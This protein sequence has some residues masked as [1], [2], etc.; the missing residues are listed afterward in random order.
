MFPLFTI[1]SFIF[2]TLIGSFL[3]VVILRYNTGKNIFGPR[4]RSVCF[5]CSK[6]LAWH[7]LVPVLS[8][9]ALR[10]RCS[11]CKSSISWQYPFVEIATGLLFAAIFKNFVELNP[12]AIFLSALY[13][14]VWSL[15][16]V[17]TVYDLRHKIIPDGIVYAF[18]VIAF[19]TVFVPGSVA[20]VA[21]LNS[22]F[23]Y[24]GFAWSSI[25]A[26][27][28]FSGFFAGLW[29]VSGGRW[30]GLGDAKL[31]LGVGLLL[32]LE[33][34]FTAMALA[35]WIG[36]S[37]SILLM[38]AGAVTKVIRQSRLHRRLAT[39]TMKSEIPFAPFIILGTLISF[40]CS[41]NIF[42]GAGALF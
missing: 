18:S 16:V 11:G 28:A 31:V 2:G 42:G 41:I 12:T 33:R 6:T 35:F 25:V 23:T 14:A 22:M 30:L 4:E 13:A 8:F 40:F 9:V 38:L 26:G 15:L 17:I 24:W 32:G 20:Y 39:L 27:L 36:A 29:Y 3:N 7:E 21:G 10:G 5:S 19:L 1:F 37:V 34:G